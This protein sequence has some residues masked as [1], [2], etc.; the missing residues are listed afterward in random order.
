MNDRKEGK[1][2]KIWREKERR[3][4]GKWEE[5]RERWMREGREKKKE[6]R[7]KERGGGLWGEIINGRRENGGEKG[8]AKDRGKEDTGEY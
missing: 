8:R 7:R 5:T 6:R 2:G 1:G 4:K 3:N